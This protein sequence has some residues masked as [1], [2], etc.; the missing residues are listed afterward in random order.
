MQDHSFDSYAARA[1]GF[2]AAAELEL[3]RELL[4]PMIAEEKDAFVAAEFGR[5]QQIM[6]CEYTQG[7]E[8]CVFH[9]VPGQTDGGERVLG[10]PGELSLRELSLL[11]HLTHEVYRLG[12][13][14]YVPLIQCY[15]EDLRRLELLA[16]AY[17]T[18]MSGHVCGEAELRELFG[19]HQTYM[20]FKSSGEVK[21]IK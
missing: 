19:G 8:Q 21:V 5:L 11:P 17:E 9:P 7:G 20:D 1:A 16:G 6:G 10:D 14:S 3:Q 4:L 13:V 15:P 12:T 2:D 18:L